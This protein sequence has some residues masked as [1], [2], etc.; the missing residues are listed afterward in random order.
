MPLKLVWFV[1]HYKHSIVVTP[2]T[3]LLV[4]VEYTTK[5]CVAEYA[6]KT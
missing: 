3:T 5:T 1:S 2:C 6:T 4:V